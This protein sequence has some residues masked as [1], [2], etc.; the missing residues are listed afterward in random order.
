MAGKTMNAQTWPSAQS[1]WKTAVA[2]DRAGFTEV[3]DTGIGDHVDQRQSEPGG[4]RTESGAAHLGG[5]SSR[6]R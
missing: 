3:F 4:E 5:W 6:A 1:P 2:S